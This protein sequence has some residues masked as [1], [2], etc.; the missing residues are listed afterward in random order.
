M[1][2]FTYLGYQ[3]HDDWPTASRVKGATKPS[4]ERYFTHRKDDS[5]MWANTQSEMKQFIRDDL[6]A[7]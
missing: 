1:P 3:V 2:D 4:T 5:V 6:A 7:N